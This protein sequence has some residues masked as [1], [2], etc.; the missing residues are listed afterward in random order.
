M[1]RISK[2]A[3]C[4]AVLS[5]RPVLGTVLTLDDALARA[6]REAPAV[7]AARLRPDEARGRLA[8]VSPWLRDNPVV[9]GA[10]GRRDADDGVSTDI[11]AGLSQTFELGGRRRARVAGANAEVAHESAAAEDAQ[12]LALQQVAASFMRAVA[13]DQ[14][15]DV[16][17]ASASLATDLERIAERRHQAGDIAD[18]DRNVARVSAARARAELRA[19]EAAREVGLAELKVALGMDAAE[20]LEVRG[21]LQR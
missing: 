15:V 2:A 4:A 20:P 7:V 18:L 17:R 8:G 5:S 13:A 14:R 16:L 11:E 6:R 1:H 10:A 12:R 21:D 9:E 3:L 19:S